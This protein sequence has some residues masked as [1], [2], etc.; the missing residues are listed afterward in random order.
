MNIRILKVLFCLLSVLFLA[1]CSEDSNYVNTLKQAQGILEDNPSN[2]LVLLNSVSDPAGNLSR[3]HYMEYV[4]ARV[5]AKQESGE[6]VRNDTLVFQAK[7]YFEEKENFRQSA[8]A[9]FYSGWVQYKN[10][11]RAE[12]L[13]LFLKAAQDAL[14]SENYLLA[15]RG[16]NNAGSIFLREEM[17]DSAA[18]YLPKALDNYRR[19][20]NTKSLNFLQTFNSL[21]R[22]YRILDQM[23]EAEKAFSEGLAL[24]KKENNKQYLGYFYNN[25]GLILYNTKRYDEALTLLGKALSFDIPVHD[26]ITTYINISLVYRAKNELDSVFYYSRLLPENISRIH[27]ISLL[28]SSYLALYN[29]YKLMNDPVK[30]LYYKEMYDEVE[31]KRI[32]ERKSH[33][34]VEARTNFLLEQKDKE[35]Q[36]G[37]KDN[38]ITLSLLLL[39]VMVATVYLLCWLTRKYGNSLEELKLHYT[40]IGQKLSHRDASYRQI[41]IDLI[42]L[43]KEMAEASRNNSHHRSKPFMYSHNNTLNKMKSAEREQIDPDRM[44]KEDLDNWATRYFESLPTGRELIAGLSDREILLFALRCEDYTEEEINHIMNVSISERLLQLEEKLLRSGELNQIQIFLLL[45]ST[46]KHCS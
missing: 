42:L 23:D 44:S 22:A 38:L 5:A 28:I 7:R 21:G 37:N 39:G 14:K 3:Q 11:R 9:N 18:V 46:N 25:L 33:Q 36:R 40:I 34:I 8:F 12:A 2:A 45:N 16:F 20:G 26:S 30:A 6:S 24:A 10:D 17:A 19:A 13:P 35:M 29:Y 27:D 15:G 31:K 41:T 43:R 32:K 4:L 1:S